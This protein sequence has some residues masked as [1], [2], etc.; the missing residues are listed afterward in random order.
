MKKVAAVLC[1]MALLAGAVNADSVIGVNFGEGETVG[2]TADGFSNWTDSSGANGSIAVLLG[3]S[4]VAV[5]WT[6][7]NTWHAGPTTNSEEKLWYGY[8]DDGN[9][10]ADITIS[11][12]NT[13]LASNA[14]A[15][16]YQVSVYL[17][18]DS[19]GSI[20]G[21]TLIYD[22]STTTVIDTL[23][24]TSGNTW[25]N[26]TENWVHAKIDS[27]VLTNDTIRIEGWPSAYQGNERGSITAVKI[28][29]IPE[30]ATMILLGLG[31][32]LLRRKK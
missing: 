9:A 28:T 32:L 14:G 8:L 26:I 30:P 18:S 29:A 10:G 11:G 2:G 31:G 17:T 23:V 19:S 3:S 6:S 1:V 12:L 21:D 24:S 4:G 27:G 15:T 25:N 20:L 22:G 16:G 5:N 13:W 7:K